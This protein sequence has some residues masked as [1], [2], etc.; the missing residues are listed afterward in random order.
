MKKRTIYALILAVSLL[1]A[2]ASPALAIDEPDSV[3]LSDITVFQDLIVT[4]D[5]LA[6]VPYAIPFGTLPDE[7]IDESFIFSIRSA[8]ATEEL[9]SVLAYPGYTLGYGDGTVSFYI[10]DGM[11]WDEAYVFRVMQN[12]AV[13]DTPEYW[14]FEIGVENYSA[15]TDQELALRAKVIDIATNLSISFSTELLGTS[16]GATVLST[17]GEVYF[18]YAIPG[19]PD[20]C[21][22]LYS[23]Q[24]RSPDYTKRSWDTTFA[25]NMLDVY[26]GN[27]FIEDFMTGSA[28]MFSVDTPTA[29]N[30]M[31]I[32]MF[33]VLML[34][35]AW[36]MKANT[37]SAF[38][39]GYALLIVLMLNGFFSMILCGFIAFISVVIGGVILFINRS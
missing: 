36:K 33:V 28:G 11:T 8:N 17:Y 7:R 19:L 1:S 23:L 29:M 39:D 4:G 21:P 13:Y 27:D 14:D 9:G 2:V 10:E 3:K 32:I 12:P 38:V 24:V 5:F 26:A 30:V 25:E 15:D 35:A 37:T 34:A 31:S 20:M 18:Q 6:V 22:Q 16:E